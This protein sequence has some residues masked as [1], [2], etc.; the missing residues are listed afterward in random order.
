MR[1][2]C[3]VNVCV[4]ET[5]RLFQGR[6]VFLG[7]GKGVSDGERKMRGPEGGYYALRRRSHLLLT[8]MTAF[9]RSSPYTRMFE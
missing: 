5:S 6:E 7:G 1:V 8:P 9:T 4:C 2:V 3:I